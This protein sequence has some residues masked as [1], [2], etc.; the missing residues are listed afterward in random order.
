MKFGKSVLGERGRRRGRAEDQMKG[1]SRALVCMAQ[2][3][4]ED[5]DRSRLLY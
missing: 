1:R 4:L 3:V 5:L 2:K